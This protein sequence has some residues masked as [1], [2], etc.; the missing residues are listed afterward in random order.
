MAEQGFVYRTDN[1]INGKVYV[2]IHTCGRGSY[3]GSGVYLNLA[4]EKYGRKNFRRTVIDEFDSLDVGLE[5]E[6]YWITK[7]NSKWPTG[8]NLNDGG[9]GN[10]NP[11]QEV[12]EKISA[13]LSGRPSAF[14]GRKHTEEAKRKIGLAN[15]NIPHPP[16]SEETKERLRIFNTGKT[17]SE[18]HKKKIS[19]ANMG[20]TK[21]IHPAMEWK[22][23][24][25]PW[26][27][28]MKKNG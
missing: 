1:L 8:Y 19:L 2:G 7:L 14:K 13:A 21:G 4:I 23:G 11:T 6:R 18:E 24:H 10:F 12:R 26:N 20:K 27:K 28:G 5:K 17:L 25:T 15:K 3:L 22:N 16:R 9:G